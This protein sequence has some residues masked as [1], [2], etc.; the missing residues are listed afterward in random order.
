M[1]MQQLLKIPDDHRDQQWED[2]FLQALSESN[3]NLMSEAAQQ[4]PDGWPYLLAQTSEGA[5]EPAQKVIQWLSQKGIGLVINPEKNYPDFVLTYGM[6]WSFR[7]TGRFFHRQTRAANVGGIEMSREDIKNAGT[8]TAEFLPEYVRAILR[9]FFRDQGLLAPRV[10]VLTFD[11]DNYELAFSVESLGNPPQEEWSGVA[12][13]ISWFLPPH[14]SVLL[15]SEAGLP[16][17]SA[18]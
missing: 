14:Y 10:L 9:E 15:I 13:A 12:E 16:P 18:L 8:P 2:S 11:G 6:L 3:I 5:Q 17:F 4:G 7:E 1:N